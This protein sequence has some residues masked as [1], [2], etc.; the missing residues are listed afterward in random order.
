[1]MPR[2]VAF[3]GP[4]HDLHH[5]SRL[6]TG[7][8]ALAARGDLRL[9]YVVPR[10]DERWLVTDPVVV[11]FDIEGASRR[12]VAVDLRDGPGVSWPIIDRVDVYLKRAFYRPELVGMAQHLAAKVQPFGLNYPCRSAAST[13]R[14]LWAAGWQIARRPTGPSRLRQ[15]LAT[16]GPS[17]FE[18]SP[19]VVVEPKVIFQTRLWTRDE[20]AADEVEPLNESRLAMVRAL[21]RAFGDRFVGGLV[22]TAFAVSRYPDDVTPHSSKVSKYLAMRKRCLVS[23]YTHGVE[24]SLAFKLGETLAASQ[25]LVAVPLRYELPA[26]LVAGEHYLPFDTPDEAVEACRRLLD[27]RAVAERMRRANH[28]Y[29]AREV[30][31][32][33]HV[34]NV[35][36]RSTP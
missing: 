5:T 7:L 21:R 20:V 30:E 19:D 34:A 32:A 8:C 29:Y 9:R 17:A 24:H 4:D 22:P 13:V 35:L 10:A 2:I 3:V 31:P 27:D 16:P 26:P 14:L 1:M 18:Q 25:C 23:V 12:R 6:L 33:A 11:C 15:Y 36:A 28:A